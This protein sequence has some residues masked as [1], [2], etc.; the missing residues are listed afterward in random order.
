MAKIPSGEEL[1]KLIG[2]LGKEVK[3]FDPDKMEFVK[4]AI[5]WNSGVKDG[6]SN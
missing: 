1:Q 5:A 6:K 3:S 4:K 2:E